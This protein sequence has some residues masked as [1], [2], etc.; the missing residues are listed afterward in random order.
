M[1]YKQYP[2]VLPS[3]VFPIASSPDDPSLRDDFENGMAQTRAKYTRI[4]R[5]WT[6][7]YNALTIAQRNTLYAFYLSVLGGS[8][9]FE[10]ENPEDDETYVVRIIS[11]SYAESLITDKYYA[12]SVLLEA[13]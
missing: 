10:W 1:A 5:R 6:I 7:K 8:E 11:N 9:A 13:M 12:I 4:R 3:P 2:S